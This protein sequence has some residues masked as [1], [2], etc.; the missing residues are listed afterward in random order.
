MSRLFAR[1]CFLTLV[2][3]TVLLTGCGSTGGYSSASSD[4]SNSTA[5]SNSEYRGRGVDSRTASAFTDS[6]CSVVN[7]ITR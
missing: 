1:L 7:G 3:M 6:G 4:S 5:S 2:S